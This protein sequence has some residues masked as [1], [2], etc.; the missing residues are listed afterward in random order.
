MI[1][2]MR[3]RAILATG[4]LLA[5]TACGSESPAPV[6][7]P[8]PKLDTISVQAAG[9]ARG[10][11]WDGVVE[12]VQQAALTA[13]TAGRVTVVNV[14]VNDRVAAGD[15]L[16][17]LTA[18]E[19][20]AG[21][22]TA[23]AQLRAAEAA[24]TEAEANYRRYAALAPAQYVSRAQIDQVRAA[25]DSAAA[26]RDAA[27]AQLSQAGQ[28]AEYTVI[29]APFS[30]IVSARQ[31]QPGESVAPGQPL[32]AVYAPGAL[33]IEVQVPQSDAVAIRAANRAKVVL[34]DGRR[35][36]A[37]E[38]TVFPAADPA[39][40]SVGVRVTL[41]DLPHSPQPGATAKVVFPIS[42]S[43]G[44]GGLRIPASALVQR[45]EVSGVY[46]LA[47]KCLALRQLRLGQRGGDGVEVI[48]GLKA[49]EQIAADPVAAVQALTAQRKAVAG[50]KDE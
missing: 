29:R 17:R 31:V 9:D 10:R 50:A 41:P 44:E 8:L 1:T 16:L 40:H 21:A 18:V 2:I 13:Q 49:G 26:A 23:R 11:G 24:A 42:T 48:A 47:E 19:Q 3:M 6:L 14:D 20:Q 15:V 5:L 25:R 32:M 22:N 46:V 35:V 39:T 7:P 36:D 12:A 27:R 45:G 38:V 30:G 4:V 28:Q 33:R 43:T 37:V 34:A